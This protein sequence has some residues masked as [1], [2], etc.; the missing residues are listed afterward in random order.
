MLAI[1]QI[2]SDKLTLTW[3]LHREVFLFDCFQAYGCEAV[4]RNYPTTYG[5]LPIRCL[6]NSKQDGVC[7]PVL[8]VSK[9]IEVSKRRYIT[10][11]RHVSSV[12]FQR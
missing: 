3:M 12:I 11:S 10:K 2:R 5:L 8:N 1:H 7:N 6:I 9:A 4:S